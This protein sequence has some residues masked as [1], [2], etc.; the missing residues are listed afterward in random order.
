MALGFENQAWR[1]GHFGHILEGK[2]YF[3]KAMF[4]YALN[5]VEPSLSWLQNGKWPRAI[6]LVS[7][8]LIYLRSCSQVHK[9]SV[10]A[11]F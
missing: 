10:C 4:W 2:S 7:I 11:L 1:H 8:M 6:G 3:Q 5:C 9:V